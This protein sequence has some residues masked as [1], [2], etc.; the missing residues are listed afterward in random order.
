MSAFRIKN[1]KGLFLQPDVNGIMSEETYRHLREVH[2]PSIADDKVRAQRAQALD[3]IAELPLMEEVWIGLTPVDSDYVPQKKSNQTGQSYSYE[4]HKHVKGYG[5]VSLGAAKGASDGDGISAGNPREAGWEAIPKVLKSRAV[6]DE[7]LKAVGGQ[8]L[9]DYFAFRGV[10]GIKRAIATAVFEEIDTDR[11]LARSEAF[12]LFVGSGYLDSKG[13]GGPL[14]RA[15]MFESAAAASRT[16]GSQGWSDWK[17]VQ[18]GVSVTA[19]VEMKGD[20][21][22]PALAGVIAKLE[23]E[24]LDKALAD[25]GIERLKQKLAELLAERSEAPESDSPPSRPKSRL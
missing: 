24:A 15:R 14:A 1:A 13:R 19:Q 22:Q 16:A 7:M 21:P 25:A 10:S 6:I 8:P 17:V 23:A 4:N 11:E 20:T 18:V 5:W 2:L 12:A 3:A 9:D